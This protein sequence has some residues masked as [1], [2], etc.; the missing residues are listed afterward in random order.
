MKK[1]TLAL[2]IAALFIGCGRA[3]VEPGKLGR[4]RTTSGW[5][6]ELLKPGRYTI[7]YHGQLYTCDATEETFTESLKIL[8]KGNIN[9]SIT[10]QVRCGV[11]VAKTQEV[12][13]VFDRVKAGPGSGQQGNIRGADKNIALASMYNTYAKMLVQSI[14][15]KALSPLTIEEFQEQRADLS[16]LIDKKVREGLLTTPLKAHAVEI[17]NIDWPD[18]ITKANEAAKQREIEILAE[19][20]RVK[21]ELVKAQGEH[22]I[23][24]ERYKIAVL[25][26]KQI[27]DSNKLIADSLKNNPEY[28]QYHTVKALAAAAEGPNNAF[29]IVPYEAMTSGK[30]DILTPALIKQLIGSLGQPAES[31]NEQNL[32]QTPVRRAPARD[33]EE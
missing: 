4:V 16:A 21:K 28:L 20:S 5:K 10:I 6:D 11:D 1:G 3:W 27:A 25:E 8:M 32:H 18:I 2:L 14:P 15:R 9:L 24:E 30:T 26:A 23:A 12:L 7:G 31:E 13:S 19:E 29:I 22:K 17:T 33:E